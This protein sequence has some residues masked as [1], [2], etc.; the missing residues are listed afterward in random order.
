M[1]R[2]SAPTFEDDF[3]SDEVVLNPYPNYTKLREAGP[4]VWLTQH[5]AWAITRY[6]AL[7]RALLSPDIF[8]SAHGCMMNAP[9]NA[10][11][12]GVMLCS[13]DPEHHV[14]RRLFAKPLQPKEL[15]AL[16]PR[17][18][19]LANA[20]VD[21]LAKRGEFDAVMDLA[22]YLPIAVV[23]ELVGLDA[24]GREKMLYWA[25]G[26]FDA[27]GPI[28]SAR[29]LAGLEI[30]QQAIGYVLERVDRANL[31]PGG[32]GEALFIAAD[33]GH[34]SEQT[35]RMM[36]ID[37]IT[38]S[39]DTTINAVSS[40]IELFAANPEQWQLLQADPSLIP[41][42]INEI[43]RIESPI[44]G[45]AREITRD[46]Q[47]GTATLR[48]GERALMLFACANRDPDKYPDPDRFDI[49]RRPSDHLGFGM[50]THLCAGMHLAKLE[51]TALFEA[52]L[53]IVARFI[54]RD[55]VR[56]PHNTLRGLASLPT[57]M[58]ATA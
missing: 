16:K 3:W 33:K 22:H 40:A 21:E 50:G 8:S 26:I 19:A 18:K 9:L 54:V 10:A 25:A 48:A 47:I 51:I 4:A 52:L 28:E 23:T 13:D 58:I 11:T 55:P 56:H 57:H 12:Q 37:Y 35:A 43:L 46:H 38:P 27:F 29:T 34:I 41:H 49:A 14:M 5:D 1:D 24:E 53:P 36:L 32:W 30:A 17:L 31:V 15:G 45:F 2:A 44:R 6:D 42:A 7:K 39:L 20:K